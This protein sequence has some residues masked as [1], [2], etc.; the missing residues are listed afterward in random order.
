MGSFWGPNDTMKEA[1]GYPR[2]W[3]NWMNQQ[4]KDALFRQNQAG[5]NADRASEMGL[6]WDTKRRENGIG[7]IDTIRGYGSQLM[8][9]VPEYLQGQKERLAQIRADW[10]GRPKAADTMA[11]IYDNLNQ[12]GAAIGRT[13]DANQSEINDTASR[14]MGRE[15]AANRT[16]VGDIQDRYAKLEANANDDYG[17]MR[18]RNAATFGALKDSSEA[19]YGDILKDVEMLKPSGEFAQARAARSFAPM[20]AST[21][22]RLRRAGV[23]GDSLQ[24]LS[25]MQR[26]EAARARAQDDAAV[27]GTGKYVDARTGALV[28]REGARERLGRGE[29]EGEIGL[30]SE[31]SGIIRN[32]GREA[33]DLYRGETVRSTGALQGIDRDRSDRTVT[34]TNQDYDRTN[35]FWDEK[36]D[37]AVFDRGLNLEDWNTG[38]NLTREAGAIDRE[39]IDLN[40]QVSD[41]GMAYNMYDLARR[42]AGNEGIKGYGRDQYGNMYRSGQMAMG[43]GDQATQNYKTAYALNAPKAGYGLKALAGVGAAGM[44]MVAPGSGQILRS[45]YGATQNGG[46]NSPYG[47]DPYAA[48][49]QYR[50][51]YGGG[52]SV[53][54]YDADGGKG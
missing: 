33:G 38:A 24:G 47:F 14:A 53:P 40:K 39:G 44:D 32:L 4:A 28:N 36:S 54:G 49:K 22:G 21:A 6:D 23:G 34:N 41:A 8:P 18:G 12:K 29:L 37:A 3:A 26:V 52:G 43:Y 27:E 46:S 7:P 16:I 19:T 10:E 15:E 42:D 45:G 9:G 13:Y 20:M 50:S 2:E 31:Q 51:K 17:D 11:T 1:A 30:H 48:Y 25:A 35:R 5:W